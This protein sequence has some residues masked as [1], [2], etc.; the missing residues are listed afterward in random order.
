MASR[1]FPHGNVPTSISGEPNQELQGA[2]MGSLAQ[3]IT[4]VQRYFLHYFDID[5]HEKLERVCADER[6]PG[7]PHFDQVKGLCPEAL[8][9]WLRL[10]G[11]DCDMVMFQSIWLWKQRHG[12]PSSLQLQDSSG[13]L[14]T[15]C[16]SCY[17]VWDTLK[18]RM[19]AYRS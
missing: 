18:G 1:Q 19:V 4:V 16:K 8:A 11:D 15:K 10:E 3:I 12:R 9:G 6:L 14:D 2:F 7:V 17:I 5:I 13:L